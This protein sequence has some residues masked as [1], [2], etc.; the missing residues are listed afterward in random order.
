M[1]NFFYC[2]K[3]FF[4]KKISFILIFILYSNFIIAQIYR[5][6]DEKLNAQTKLISQFFKRFNNEENSFGIK[7]SSNSI[8]FRSNEGRKEMLNE[9]FDKQDTVLMEELKQNFI[10]EVTNDSLALFIDFFNSNWVAQVNANFLYK[11]REE[12]IILFFKLETSNNASKWILQNIFFK[13]YFKLFHK[14]NKLKNQKFISPVSHELEFFNLVKIFNDYQ[15]IEYYT[16]DDYKID[17]LSLFLYDIKQQNLKFLGINGKIKFHFFQ[18]KNWY[19]SI[20]FFN[21]NTYNSGWLISK[22]MK[23]SEKNKKNILNLIYNQ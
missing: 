19:F 17:F 15:N 9:L 6:D 8:Y 2:K 5:F 7:Y 10:K 11:G 4:F 18:I 3:R 13:E 12:E 22:L 16:S 14:E 23:M 21:R 20:S 1:K